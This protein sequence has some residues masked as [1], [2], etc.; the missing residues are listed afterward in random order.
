VSQVEVEVPAGSEGA[1]A[2]AT[3]PAPQAQGKDGGLDGAALAA[4]A[5]GNAWERAVQGGRALL[6]DAHQKANQQDTERA[7]ADQGAD[8]SAKDNGKAP[9]ADAVKDGE[10]AGAKDEKAGDEKG[11]TPK[12]GTEPKKDGEKSAEG[13][14]KPK[15]AQYFLVDANGKAVDGKIAWPE[16]AKM[17]LTI[18]G[19]PVT[20]KSPEHLVT[21]AQQGALFHKE[22]ARANR[23]TNDVQSL[24]ER[25]ERVNAASQDVLLAVLFGTEERTAEELA[26][27][28]REEL[29]PFRDPRYRK[30]LEA[31]RKLAD[32][33]KAEETASTEAAEARTE[34]IWA[35]ADEVFEDS[36]SEFPYLE[37]G[38]AVA[39]KSVLHQQYVTA[40]KKAVQQLAPDAKAQKWTPRQYA[41]AVEELASQVLTHEALKAAMHSLNDTYARRLKGK[42][43]AAETPPPKPSVPAKAGDAK[44]EDITAEVAAHNA[45]VDRKLE[46]ADATRT[47]KGGGSSPSGTVSIPNLEGQSYEEQQAAWK[48]TLRGAVR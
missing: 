17:R 32:T 43:P 27:A 15:G 40:H 41:D 19:Q 30:G 3:T 36:L 14:A 33:E 47:L 23:L 29:A 4:L 44:G 6:A 39:V 16:G 25:V 42:A 13:D 35:E 34:A 7:P 5:E 31:E 20:V 46:Q 12:D 48:K 11:D 8:A 26:D 21:M 22:Q 38:D 28:L 2:S 9:T 18:G 1:A 10:R 37:S 24:S 45:N